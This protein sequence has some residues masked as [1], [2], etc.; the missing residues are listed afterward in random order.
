[1]G[2]RELTYAKAI[3]EFVPVAAVPPGP[4]ISPAVPVP[5]SKNLVQKPEKLSRLYQPSTVS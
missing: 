5:N 4:V 3:N 1:M 2:V